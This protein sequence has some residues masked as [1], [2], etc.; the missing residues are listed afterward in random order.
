MLA[1]RFND[2]QD[3]EQPEKNVEGDINADDVEKDQKLEKLKDT[4][5]PVD[6]ERTPTMAGRELTYV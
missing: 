3:V 6:F 4:H 1:P 2:E 5:S